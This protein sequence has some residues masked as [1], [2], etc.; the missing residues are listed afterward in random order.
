MIEELRRFILVAQSGNVSQSAEKVF[1]TQSALSQSIKRLEK[2]LGTKLFVQRGK[3]LHITTE[4]KA[5]AEIGSKILE[6]WERAKNPEQR[7]SGSPTYS[8]GLFDGAALRLGKYVAENT[9][10]DL[11]QLELTIGSSS[12]LLAKLQLGTLDIAICVIDPKNPQPKDTLLI[13]SFT[14]ELIPVAA[15]HYKDK[16][17]TIP[18]IVYNTG[19]NTRLQID[20]VFS[21]NGIVPAFFAQSSSV[22]FMKELALLG[23]GVALLPKNYI[24]TELKQGLLTK[25]KLPLTFQ[26]TF[27]IYL[28]KNGIL[29]ATDPLLTDLI[30]N[31]Q[32]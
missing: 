27:G 22:S 14:E 23:S 29:Q 31:L 25:Q 30:K 13:K 15:Q 5:I 17:E 3:S 11:F 10:H 18:F 24:A 28:Q 21:K 1:I 7:I 8:L 6:L 16:L 26:R 9:K 2:E 4:G 32:S 12:K 20:D 19:S